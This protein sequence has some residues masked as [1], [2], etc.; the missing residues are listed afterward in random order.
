MCL[1]ITGKADKVRTTLLDTH[2]LL[3]DIFTSNPDGI[4]IMYGTASGLKVVK[5]LPKSLADATSFIRRMPTDARDIAIHFR[6]TTHGDTDLLN[7]HPYDVIPG[8]ISMMH[9]GVLHTGNDADKSK[10]D[11]WHFIRDYLASAVKSAPDL[12]YDNGFLTMVAEFIGNNRFVFMNGDGRISHVNYDQG[13]EYD[14]MWFSNEYAWKPYRLI[15]NRQ[16]GNKYGKSFSKYDSRF[17][18]DEEEYGTP[19]S[20]TSLT[21]TYRADNDDD[22]LD[23]VLDMPTI[24]S[25][26]RAVFDCDVDLI[27]DWLSVYPAYTLRMLGANLVAKESRY[28]K[29]DELPLYMNQMAHTLIDGDIDAAIRVCH[30]TAS[31]A[32]Y[33]A[34]VISY[35]LDWDHKSY[36]AKAELV[37]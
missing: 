3:S 6:W 23:D 4:G 28:S 19:Y 11:T 32:D 37:N 27:S 35:Y 1:I 17:Y 16:S 31:A 34:E 2:G 26:E 13:T 25:L 7:C 12:V 33:T 20:S 21:T 15:P 36:V 18:D 30:A 8:F 14:G 24:E 10:S 29:L 22:D 9:N 5:T